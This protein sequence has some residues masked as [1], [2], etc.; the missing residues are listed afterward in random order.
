MCLLQ[1]LSSKIAQN[2]WSKHFL[3]FSANQVFDVLNKVWIWS[4][5]CSILWLKVWIPKAEGVSEWKYCKTSI[6]K[7]DFNFMQ[8]FPYFWQRGFFKEQFFLNQL[9]FGYNLLHYHEGRRKLVQIVYQSATNACENFDMELSNSLDYLKIRF[10]EKVVNLLNSRLTFYVNNFFWRKG[11]VWSFYYANT[12]RFCG[13][14][15][16]FNTFCYDNYKRR[17]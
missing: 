8:V 2:R 12:E 17:S 13:R 15:G 6:K 14:P 3:A 16:R 5:Y 7:L 11:S 1:K 9:Q 4:F 10:F